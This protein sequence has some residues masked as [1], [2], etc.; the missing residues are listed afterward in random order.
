M[1]GSSLVAQQFK[2]LVLSLQWLRSLLW[3]GF[4]PWTRKFPI[5]RVQPKRKTKQNKT[6]DKEVNT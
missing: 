3:H 4:D 6:L 5:L 1:G 2:D